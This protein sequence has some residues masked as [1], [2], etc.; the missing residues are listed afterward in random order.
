LTLFEVIISSIVLFSAKVLHQSSAGMSNSLSNSAAVKASEGGSDACSAGVVCIVVVHAFLLCWATV[1][2]FSVGF[3][4][5]L[6][7]RRHEFEWHCCSSA[8][9]TLAKAALLRASRGAGGASL[10][11]SRGY[12]LLALP[13]AK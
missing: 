7:A 3:S 11:V 6:L 8:A 10:G 4:L 13:P 12:L 2:P 5:G 9:H 1:L